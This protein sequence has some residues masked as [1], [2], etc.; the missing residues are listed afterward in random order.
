[1]ADANDE[2]LEEKRKNAAETQQ[3]LNTFIDA[4]YEKNKEYK[5]TGGLSENNWEEVR[6]PWLG[7]IYTVL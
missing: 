4:M 2:G 1:M 6:S 7:Y 3:E 5:Y